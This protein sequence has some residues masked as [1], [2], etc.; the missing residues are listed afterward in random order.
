MVKNN[1][2]LNN[3][4]IM[5]GVDV[6]GISI[7]VLIIGCIIWMLRNRYLESF[8]V[9]VNEMVIPTRCP[10]YLVTDGSHYYLLNTSKVFD[11]VNNPLRFDTHE[12]ARYYLQEN[13]C[14]NLELTD[15]VVKKNP[16]DVSVPYEREC[17]KKVANQIFD[18]DT[19]NFYATRDDSEAYN[20][21]MKN[22][23][24]IN[25]KA[26]QIKA[27]IYSKKLNNITV[28]EEETKQ[29]EDL[30][31]QIGA[32]K[33]KYAENTNRI[34]KD[35]SEYSDYNIEK[36]MI[37]D[38]QTENTELKDD[39]FIDNFAKYFNNLNENIG[40]EYLYI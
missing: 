27:K 15:L 8:I 17:A 40:Q 4:N 24:I 37:Q 31:Q 23:M 11:G 16:K 14:P 38:T 36:C 10:D 33:L 19:C 25:E 21:Y 30:N 35:L 32:L 9:T 20:T 5:G 7:M 39:K 28:S 34:N 29:L 6:L 2:V 3:V 26:N 13:N 18:E 1:K 12:A 22:L